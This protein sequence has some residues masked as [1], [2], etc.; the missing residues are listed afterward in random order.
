MNVFRPIL[1]LLLVPSLFTNAILG[2]KSW[3]MNHFE[4]F[5]LPEDYNRNSPPMPPTKTGIL[6]TF[7]LDTRNQLWDVNEVMFLDPTF[8]LNIFV[9]E[10]QN[11]FFIFTYS[12]KF[13]KFSYVRNVPSRKRSH[14]QLMEKE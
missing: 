8:L 7:V 6:K 2:Q 4:G 5:S 13:Y 3:C 1:V 11:D 9:R 14:P 10:I 12:C